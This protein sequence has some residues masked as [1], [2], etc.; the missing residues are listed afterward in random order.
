MIYITG[1]TH[2]G[3]R[4][5]LF[6]V[7]GALHRLS[8][9]SFP[10]QKEM[11]RDDYVIV[12]GDFGCVWEYDSR[13]DPTMSAWGTYL[14]GAHGESEQEKYWLDQLEKKPF[15]LLFCDG[16]HENYD[17]LEGA[18]PEVDYAG[19]RAH[20]IR[21]NVFHL[22]RGYVFTVDGAKIF[23]FGGARSHDIADGIVRPYEYASRE[24]YREARRRLDRAHKQYRVE[25]ISWWE[26]E[27]PSEEE[28]ARGRASL[29]AHQNR[30]DFV[31]SHEAPQSVAGAMGFG[32]PDPLSRYLQE[33]SEEASY[34]KWFFGHYH[35][36]R[37][38]FGKFVEL[39]E[40]I[41]RIR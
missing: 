12:C 9:R 31:V 27:M 17:R 32:S 14:G 30:V 6:S 40:Q 23:V 33:I 24:A 11:T 20:R 2:G 5:G 21:E 10:E 39:Y 37:Q 4:L 35:D 26:R 36:N 34:E 22:M 15:T 18:Y 16:N 28:M 29:A 8:T 19:G 41:V 38:I 13:Y 25:H 7:D 3:E 1:D